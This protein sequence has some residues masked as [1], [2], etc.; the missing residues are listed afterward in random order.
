[1]GSKRQKIMSIAVHISGTIVSFMIHMWKYI[2]SGLSGE[3][4]GQKITQNDKNSDCKIAEN[5]LKL[6]ITLHILGTVDH[7]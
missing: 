6:A 5:D 2:F 1:M 7:I 3:K 4:R